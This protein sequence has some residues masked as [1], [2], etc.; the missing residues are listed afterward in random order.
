[1]HHITLSSYV[2]PTKAAGE[3]LRDVELDG[4][5]TTTVLARV[6]ATRHVALS[7]EC[8]RVSVVEGTGRTVALSSVF[9]IRRNVSAC[10]RKD[11]K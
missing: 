7:G 11:A 8:Q 6:A 10:D 5:G 3:A 1:M 2:V 9:D 4:I